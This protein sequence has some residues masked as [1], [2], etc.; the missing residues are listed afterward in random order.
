MSFLVR[1]LKE[2]ANP[3]FS[4]FFFFFFFIYR[5][6]HFNEDGSVVYTSN[7]G[8]TTDVAPP[9]FEEAL[10]AAENK[11]AEEEAVPEE[12]VPE[13]TVPEE[14]VEEETVEE[15]IQP[16]ISH[17]VEETPPVEEEVLGKQSATTSK[18]L[19]EYAAAGDNQTSLKLDEIVVVLEADS[20][21]WT[22]VQSST[23]AGFVP[24]SYLTSDF[25]EVFEG[26]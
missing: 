25:T 14:T 7:T 23:G 6:R 24:S 18:A 1:L 19:Y 5:N 3:F 17:T 10:A 15:E 21:G 9:G 16:I 4:I 2:N 22:G 11:K 20:G 8:K 12:T 26:K 13:E